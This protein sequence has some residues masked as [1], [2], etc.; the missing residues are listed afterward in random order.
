[1]L[2]ILKLAY[3]Q[4]YCTDSNQILRSHRDHQGTLHGW[5]KQA[6]NKSKMADGRHLEKSQTVISP[7]RLTD[8]HYIIPRQTSV[9]DMG[10]T[11]ATVE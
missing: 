11:S 3:Y 9:V 4:N 1:M 10:R 2:K 5:S 6:Y 7:Q 8:L